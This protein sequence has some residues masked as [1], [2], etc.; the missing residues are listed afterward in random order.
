MLLWRH[1]DPEADWCDHVMRRFSRLAYQA[2]VVLLSARRLC[3]FL[4]KRELGQTESLLPVCPVLWTTRHS[5]AVTFFFLSQVNANRLNYG[6]SRKTI[7]LRDQASHDCGNVR[8]KKNIYICWAVLRVGVR[9]GL[10]N[11]FQWDQG[12]C[13]EFCYS[14]LRLKGLGLVG[15]G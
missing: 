7:N 8:V 3:L 2:A 4:W 12:A 5:I 1:A 14:V 9:L 15:L 6:Q 13:C 11:Y 10:N